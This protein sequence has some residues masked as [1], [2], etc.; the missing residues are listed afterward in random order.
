MAAGEFCLCT[1]S[2]CLPYERVPVQ[3]TYV[4]N[5]III[6]PNYLLSATAEGLK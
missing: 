5:R 4:E 3:G 2:P 1:D 6:P